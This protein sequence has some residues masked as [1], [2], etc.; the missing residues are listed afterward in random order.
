MEQRFRQ[1]DY[2]L[3]PDLVDLMVDML[4]MIVQ[5]ERSLAQL[6]SGEVKLI[7]MLLSSAEGFLGG[8]SEHRFVWSRLHAVCSLLVRVLPWLK[9]LALYLRQTVLFWQ[10]ERVRIG[11]IGISERNPSFA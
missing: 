3:V 10:I 2:L 4:Q 6:W 8:I 7:L 1:K 11:I 5:H 9:F